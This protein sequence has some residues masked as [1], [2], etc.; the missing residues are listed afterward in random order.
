[1]KRKLAI[2]TVTAVALIGGGS[3]AAV[4]S[5][6]AT[7]SA[8]S[9]ARAVDR[10]DHD[11]DRDEDRDSGKDDKD[12]NDELRDDDKDES[13][14]AE[15]TGTTAAEAAEAA[16]KA[17]PGTVTGVDLDGGRQGPVWEVEVT[18][19]RTSH[20][21]RLDGDTNKV[22]DKRTE[23]DDEAYPGSKLTAADVARKAA[24]RGTV[25]SVELDDDAKAPTWEVETTQGGKG[26]KGGK[27]QE[28]ELSVDGRTGEITRSAADH[29]DD[30]RDDDRDGDDRDD[31]RDGDD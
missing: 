17:A 22:L 30:G 18:E 25:T 2:A 3:V 11:D 28:T 19:G 15:S 27:G 20:E 13:R 26:G 5:D 23:R 16:L 7:R 9:S 31:D 12:D 1:M 24:E 6:D 14:A 8:S 21:V 29:D 4:A 10:D